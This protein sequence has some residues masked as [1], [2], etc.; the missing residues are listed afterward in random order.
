MGDQWVQGLQLTLLGMGMT[1]A[2][3]GALVVGM[4]LMTAVTR[5]ERSKGKSALRGHRDEGENVSLN[6]AALGR[7]ALPSTE[8]SVDD[9][10]YRAAAAAVAVA[11]A[12][13]DTDVSS[14]APPPASSSA[15]DIYIRGRHVSHRTRYDL[16][17]RR[18]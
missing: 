18:R 5:T 7:G 3:I 8:E 12:E 15:W 6:N 4:Y 2:S 16:R 1:F 13:A 17:Q 9:A 10:K 14:A 11:L